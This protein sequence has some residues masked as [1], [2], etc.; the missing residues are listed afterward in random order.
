MLLGVVMQSLVLGY[1]TWKTDWDN[2]VKKASER[3]N[4]WLLK[5]SEEESN[6]N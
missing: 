1:V 5:P 4:K 6:G 3:L 2:E